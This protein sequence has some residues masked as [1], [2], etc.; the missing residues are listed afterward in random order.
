M[1]PY[2]GLRVQPRHVPRLG[3]ESNHLLVYETTAN[4]ATLDR[5]EFLQ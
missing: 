2:L 5:V 1:P 3:M 4:Q